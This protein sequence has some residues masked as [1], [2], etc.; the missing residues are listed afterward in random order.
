MKKSKITIRNKADK[1]LQDYIR[2][3]YHSCLICGGRCSCGHHFIPKSNSLATRYYIP[4][5]IPICRNC[6]C[7]AHTQPH[8]IDPRIC[9]I[10]GSAWYA[11]LINKKKQKVKF[12]LGWITLQ[13][14]ELDR[15]FKVE[16]LCL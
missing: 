8:L 9:F 2:S 14:E 13:Y 5:I 6:H 1:L 16:D 15:L 12:T 7:L 3:K 10:K 11:D 4:N